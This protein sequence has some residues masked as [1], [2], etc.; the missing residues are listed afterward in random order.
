MTRVVEAEGAILKRIVARTPLATY[1][2]LSR[3]AFV[4]YD[5]AQAKTVWALQHRRRLALVEG[6]DVL[7]SAERYDLAGILD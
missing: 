1:R 7:A 5:A 2:G 6:D 3:E 4:K